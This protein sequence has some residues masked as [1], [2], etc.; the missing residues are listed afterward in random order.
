MSQ[1]EE[2][3]NCSDNFACL[4]FYL[5]ISKILDNEYQRQI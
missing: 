1:V 4:V 3:I 5:M 2:Y